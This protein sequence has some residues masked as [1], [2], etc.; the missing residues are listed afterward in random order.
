MDVTHLHHSCVTFLG[1]W[2]L[3][4]LSYYLYP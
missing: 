2:N 3:D 4:P 1:M